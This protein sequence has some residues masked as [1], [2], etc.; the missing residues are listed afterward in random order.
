M[1]GLIVI[2]LSWFMALAYSHI[3]L[4]EERER[5][6]TGSTVRLSELLPPVS[7]VDLT[8]ASRRVSRVD[9][10]RNKLAKMKKVPK[11]KTHLPPPPNC[12]PLQ[13]SCKPPAPPCCEPCAFCFCH[14][15]QTVCYYRMGNPHC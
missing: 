6:N 10:E 9:A 5:D 14:L 11:K 15:F 7:I 4:E 2:V 13:S 3:V 1:N 12:A 8:R